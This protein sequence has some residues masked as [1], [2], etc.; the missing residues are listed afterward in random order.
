M[1]IPLPRGPAADVA[2]LDA[3]T[4]VAQLAARILAVS[5]E[6]GLAS[7][8]LDDIGE[9][10]VDG[11]AF[12]VVPV[13]EADAA[14][15]GAAGRRAVASTG[16]AAARALLRAIPGLGPAAA[17]NLLV[18]VASACGSGAA[19]AAGGVSLL[20]ELVPAALGSALKAEDLSIV[21]LLLVKMEANLHN[22]GADFAT[23]LVAS[24]AAAAAARL[25]AA[26]CVPGGAVYLLFSPAPDGRSSDGERMLEACWGWVVAGSDTRSERARR[27]VQA[28]LAAA[29]RRLPPEARAGGP[30]AAKFNVIAAALAAALAAK[31]PELL[32]ELEAAAAE[33]GRAAGA[34]ALAARCGCN[35]PA[36]A[37]TAGLTRA[38]AKALFPAQRCSRCRVVRYCQPE[39]QRADWP[40]HA[41]VCRSL[42]A[43]AGAAGAGGEA[44]APVT[45]ATSSVKEDHI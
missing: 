23:T 33:H 35:N 43:G 13:Q 42:L 20:A 7:V 19:H 34:R 26:E 32:A 27:Q 16:V 8:E 6:L 40:A 9:A 36:C 10:L 5:S 30:R 18:T 15:Q 37:R 21:D 11:V 28:A 31:E 12:L 25:A 22:A 1:V 17:A 29:V 24:G 2:L 4:A 45:A 14:G 39:C 41:A 3:A 38:Q 44:A